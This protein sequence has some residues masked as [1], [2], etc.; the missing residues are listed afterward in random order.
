MMYLLI[1]ITI[2]IFVSSI[3]LFFYWLSIRKKRQMAERLDQYS[4]AEK[5]ISEDLREISPMI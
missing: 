4:K 1:F 3:F 2:S 5:K